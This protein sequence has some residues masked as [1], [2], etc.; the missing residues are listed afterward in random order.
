[1]RKLINKIAV[2]FLASILLSSQALAVSLEITT[3]SGRNEGIKNANGQWLRDG[4]II[5]VIKAAGEEPNLPNA[6]GVPQGGDVLI[7]EIS[8][9]H[10]FPFNPDE[11]KFDD[12]VVVAAGEKIFVRAFD[13][14]EL[15]SASS[16]GDSEVYVVKGNEGEYWNIREGSDSSA[17]R[18]SRRLK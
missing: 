18:L 11:G 6:D 12:Q 17:F 9:G 16:Y 4:S 14:N 2:I 10:N 13:S 8:S 7:G 5:Q 15:S 3:G 1:M